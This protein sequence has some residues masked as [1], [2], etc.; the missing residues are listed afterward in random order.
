MKTKWEFFYKLPFFLPQ[1]SFLS[2]CS[3]YFLI[4]PL[5]NPCLFGF[6]PLFWFKAKE[7]FSCHNHFLLL[8][9]LSFS[10]CLFSLLFFVSPPSRLSKNW[11]S[12]NFQ[13]LLALY[14]LPW[15]IKT[16]SSGF[17]CQ[18]PSFSWFPNISKQITVLLHISIW[19]SQRLKFPVHVLP[20]KFPPPLSTW[21]HYL[22]FVNLEFLTPLLNIQSPNPTDPI[23]N[24]KDH[25]LS[26]RNTLTVSSPV[27]ATTIFCL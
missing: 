7:Q 19:V 12:S 5:L 24:K 26:T 14:G 10:F 8:G 13:C 9:F 11:C 25:N 22:L 1:P 3:L 16:H 20:P 21:H 15:M 17:K 27:Q 6:C 4:F 2:I 23:S 18:L